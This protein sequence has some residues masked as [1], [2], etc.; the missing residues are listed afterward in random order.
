MGVNA[1]VLVSW[2]ICSAFDHISH[3]ILVMDVDGVLSNK[4]ISLYSFPSKVS[5]QGTGHPR[6]ME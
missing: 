5:K 2:G 4:N 1:A 6:M 3:Q